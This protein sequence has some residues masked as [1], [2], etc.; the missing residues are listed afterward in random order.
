MLPPL[1]KSSSLSSTRTLPLHKTR[2]C[3]WW[4]FLDAHGNIGEELTT[5]FKWYRSKDR[6]VKFFTDFQLKGLCSFHA[7]GGEGF[8]SIGLQNGQWGK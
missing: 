3:W 8:P 2:Y 7:I 1:I 4:L 6:T 5:D